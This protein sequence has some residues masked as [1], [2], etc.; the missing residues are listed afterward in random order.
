M[1]NDNFKTKLKNKNVD[2][3]LEIIEEI[4]LS[5]CKSSNELKILNYLSK[6]K[7]DEIRARVAEIL[8]IY[9]NLEA[10]KILI[11]LLRDNDPL[12]RVNACDSLYN[13]NSLEVLNLLKNRVLYDKSSLVRGY[14][15][16]SLTDIALN[17]K[18]DFKDLVKFFQ[19]VLEKEKNQWVRINLYKVL[20]QLG[21]KKYLTQLLKE[22]NNRLYKNRSAVV[23]AIVEIISGEN[24]NAIKTALIERMKVEKTLAVNSKIENVINNLE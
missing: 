16:A 20:Y 7:D 22:L 15:T 23:S 13:S 8:V 5:N 10:E 18:I 19:N 6:D 1:P 14:A 11:S 24:V 3:K 17:I 2:E 12:V 4:E 9:D 21:D